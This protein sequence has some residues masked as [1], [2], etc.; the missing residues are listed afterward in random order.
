MKQFWVQ[1][2]FT[3][4]L[5]IICASFAFAFWSMHFVLWISFCGSSVIY[6]SVNFVLL[7]L[8]FVSFSM[9]ITLCCQFC[10]PCI[11]LHASRTIHIIYAYFYTSHSM[12]FLICKILYEIASIR[13]ILGKF[14]TKYM[15]P[16]IYTSLMHLILFIQ[17]YGLSSDF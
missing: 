12:H 14:L 8:V 4:L 6:H 11:Q 1:Y 9:H 3:L 5:L 2:C 16:I 15:Q 13:S 7:F 10:V 17:L